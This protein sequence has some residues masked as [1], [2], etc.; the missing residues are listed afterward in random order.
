M[1]ISSEES[2]CKHHLSRIKHLNKHN[3]STYILLIETPVVAAISR[4]FWENDRKCNRKW[5]V[6]LLCIV[7]FSLV[8][9]PSF[10]VYM[11]FEQHHQGF[12]KPKATLT[13]RDGAWMPAFVWK[14]REGSRYHEPQVM[15]ALLWRSVL[16]S[17]C[18]WSL[19]ATMTR[20]ALAK[21]FILVIL[22]LIICLP[23]FFSLYR[24]GS[25]ETDPDPWLCPLAS[26]SVHNLLKH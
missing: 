15:T 14:P 9:W 20:A 6:E 22:A 12:V 10:S 23:E 21:L 13:C 16:V 5:S 17:T 2:A 18:G 26:L 4:S 25:P 11:N 3:I 7:C 19:G 1:L 24:G 8:A